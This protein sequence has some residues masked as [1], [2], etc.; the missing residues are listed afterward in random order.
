MPKMG[1]V[2]KDIF[3]GLRCNK[4]WETAFPDWLNTASDIVRT[5]V[6][7]FDRAVDRSSFESFLCPQI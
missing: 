1:P 4:T 2:F 6:T 7:S 3:G 5:E